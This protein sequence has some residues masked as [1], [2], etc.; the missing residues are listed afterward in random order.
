MIKEV[1]GFKALVKVIEMIVSHGGTTIISIPGKDE[2]HII[3]LSTIGFD[4][5]DEK[6]SSF[7]K[8]DI[9]GTIYGFLEDTVFED[10]TP[11]EEY[12][13]SISIY[14]KLFNTTCTGLQNIEKHFSL[15]LK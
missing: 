1:K 3:S 6:V 5:I 2:Q 11:V 13:C 12:Q 10:S 7:N 9:E 15:L 8:G 14:T 4:P